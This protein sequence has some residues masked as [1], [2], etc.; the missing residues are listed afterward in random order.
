MIPSDRGVTEVEQ[1]EKG[2]WAGP[3][4][5]PEDDGAGAKIAVNQTKNM[6]TN[7]ADR[8]RHLTESVAQNFA[9]SD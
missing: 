8:L 9:V 2:E 4:E 1:P 6:S 3:L 5:P 7:D